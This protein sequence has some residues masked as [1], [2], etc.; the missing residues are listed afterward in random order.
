MMPIGVILRIWQLSLAFAGDL[1]K[2]LR[3]FSVTPGE[4]DVLFCLLN[5]RPPYQ[6]RPSDISRGCYV[7]T[8]AITS[9]VDRLIKAGLVERLASS[10]DRREIFVRLTPAGKKI[11]DKIKREVAAAS[12]VADILDGMGPH[13]GTE[14]IRLLRTFCIEVQQRQNGGSLGGAMPF[15]ARL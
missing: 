11:A 2:I 3:P 4:M 10:A 8:G 7:T 13:D 15:G 6:Q 5:G 1:Q 14:F 12:V 9:R